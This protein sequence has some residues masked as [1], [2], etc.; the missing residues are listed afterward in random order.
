[1][2]QQQQQFD[3]VGAPCKCGLSSVLRQVTKES[4]NQGRYFYTCPKNK[5]QDP[6]DYFLW[7]D[8]EDSKVVTRYNK[9]PQASP[10]KSQ[11]PAVKKQKFVRHNAVADLGPAIKAAA[12]EAKGFDAQFDT[13]LAQ[14]NTANMQMLIRA[15]EQNTLASQHMAGM[16]DLLV[17]V[18][19][20]DKKKSESQSV[21]VI[22]DDENDDTVDLVA[23]SPVLKPQQQTKQQ[24]ANH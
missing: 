22:E 9:R 10:S 20:Q 5:N 11:Q 23:D 3:E 16:M 8:G 14:L 1:M 18:L 12:S 2:A 7:A 19:Q 13:K 6:C 21:Q 15:I 24:P 17:K 4:A